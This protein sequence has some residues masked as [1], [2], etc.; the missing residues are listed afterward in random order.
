MI[1]KHMRCLDPKQSESNTMESMK[2]LLNWLTFLK[3][4]PT[5]TGNTA[6]LQFK[7]FVQTCLRIKPEKIQALKKNK[8]RL[9]DSIFKE[10]TGVSMDKELC[11]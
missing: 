6:L 9:D 7:S 10:L 1:I 5:S 11:K 8:H 4:I 2:L 3:V